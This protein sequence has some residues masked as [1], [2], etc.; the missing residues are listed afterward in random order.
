[1]DRSLA[2]GAGVARARGA[3]RPLIVL[4]RAAAT[5][6]RPGGPWYN[7]HGTSVSPSLRPPHRGP[8]GTRPFRLARL[9]GAALALV[10]LALGAPAPS[11]HGQSPP[12]RAAAAAPERPPV[13]ITT[14]PAEARPVQRT[15]ETVGSLLAWEDGLAK[16]QISGTLVRLHADLGAYG[17]SS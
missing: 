11:S 6:E 16:A 13:R 17:P 10:W 1:M 15:V 8:R 3:T 9:A 4:W 14:A 5:P 12:A 7:G 2:K